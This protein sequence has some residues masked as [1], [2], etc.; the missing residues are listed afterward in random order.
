MSEMINQNTQREFNGIARR[1]QAAFFLLIIG[2][3]GWLGWL[4]QAEAAQVHNV[5]RIS[6]GT[7]GVQANN[8]SYYAYL[9]ADGRY[10]AFESWASNWNPGD[11]TPNKVDIFVRD[12]VADTTVQVTF[13]DDDSFHPM[14]T[15]DGRYV[16]FSSYAADLVPDD[17][18]SHVWL[19]DGL[20]VFLYDRVA[21]SLQRVSLNDKGEEIAGNSVGNITPDGRI[22]VFVSNGPNVIFGDANGARNSAIY[23]RDWRTGEIE[24]ITYG[25]ES[26]TAFPNG[27][28]GAVHASHD[29]RYI[30]F[31]S[32]SSN[33]VPNDTNGVSDI[34][35]YD[36]QMKTT[37]RISEPPGGG[38]ANG[39]SHQ[40][41][42]SRDGRFIAFSSAAS[43]LVPGDTNNANDIFL[44]TVQT[45]QIE[46][47]NLSNTGAQANA[48]SRDPSVCDDGRY[49][50]YT[51]E[52]TNLV[53]GDTNGE[54]DVFLYDVARGETTVVSVNA[55]GQWGNGRAHRSYITDDCRI[56]AY[57]TEAD[58]VVPNDTNGER[59]IFALDIVLPA[60][61]SQSSVAVS[62]AVQP[63]GQLLYTYTLRNVGMETAVA[64]FSAQIPSNTTYVPGSASG[65]TFQNGLVSWSG[66][67]AA[68]SEYTVSF[69]VNIPAGLT[70]FALITNQATLTGDGNT[71][72]LGR[73]LAVNGLE[74][75]LP[76]IGAGE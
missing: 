73:T 46:R 75:F 61:F 67:L 22:I 12:T 71:Y 45:G 34:F 44:Y 36:R 8:S 24:R 76:L 54:R 37:T 69:S 18:N 27:G 40:V 4:G 7:G 52:A 70:D 15:A 25:I 68:G 5:R 20:D 42:I 21:N 59:D 17:N 66:D 53:P 14:I 33:L 31:S 63:G 47:V 60:D 48:V 3:V 32:D 28:F 35:L 9:S 13:G 65:G 58:N 16:A 49:V 29:G 26:A 50:S 43:N 74:T 19:R 10:A 55:Q 56:I 72:N 11:P 6:L 2:L 38:N 51:S 39:N 57:A 1:R 30:A 64:T 62:G 23:L 41:Q